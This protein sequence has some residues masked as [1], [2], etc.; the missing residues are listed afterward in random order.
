MFQ[1]AMTRQGPVRPPYPCTKGFHP[2][3]SNS[4]N[5]L[6][7]K[8]NMVPA[9]TGKERGSLT[10]CH[11][12]SGPAA[13]PPTRML[14]IRGKPGNHPQGKFTFPADV[15]GLSWARSL[16]IFR[17]PSAAGEACPLIPTKQYRQ[18]RIQGG[19]RPGA[20][21]GARSPQRIFQVAL[22]LCP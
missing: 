7:E 15:P 20:G 10:W 18:L 4:G 16:Q 3:D 21:L 6:N 22:E 12:A 1:R 14:C 17:N 2:L 5:N 8:I 13:K 11:G 19:H 9:A